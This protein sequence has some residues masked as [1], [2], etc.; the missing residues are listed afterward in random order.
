MKD[1][2]IKLFNLEPSELEDVELI[3]SDY[4]VNALVTM[5]VRHQ[6]CPRC[7]S[8][9]KTIHD[10]RPRA[11]SHAI[12]NDTYTNILFNQRRYRCTHCD[13]TFPEANPFAYP[14]RR[15]S[16]YLIL[17]VMKMLKNPRATFSQVANEVG[18]SASSVVRIFDKYAGITPIDMPT[19]LCIDE[20]YAIKYRQKIYACVL[21]DMQTSQIYDLLQ[22]RKKADLSEYFSK[23][24]REERCKVKYVCIDMWKNYR[25]LAAVYFPEAK[26][27]VDSFHVVK[28]I[29]HNFETIRIRVMKRFETTSE[30][31]HLLKHYSWLLT[32]NS[33]RIKMDEY[34]NLHRY[35]Y[36]FDSQY[37]K[38]RVIIDKMLSFDF[39]LLAGYSMKENYLYINSHSTTENIGARLESYI[40]ELRMYDVK[41]LTSTAKTLRFWKPEIIN[42]FDRISGQRISNGP[43][44]S[45][46]SRIKVIK[47]NGNGYRNFD[48]FRKRVLYS[49][50]DS[51]GLKN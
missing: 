2:I 45:V 34:I 30:E 35:Y 7:K 14:N 11:L 5:K 28:L 44:E 12:I 31:Y 42:S 26:I 21:V 29:L 10:Y 43:I 15:V 17:R 9:T 41:E 18:I 51:S 16:N 40:G 36:L 1:T 3:S 8:T 23:I 37:V 39:E 24:S 20:V 50:N 6:H 22:S 4:S 47:Q 32:H 13:K 25:D 33:S 46:N 19:C 38:P 49:L 48:R 27:C